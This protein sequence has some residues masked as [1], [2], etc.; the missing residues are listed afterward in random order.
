MDVNLRRWKEVA[1]ELAAIAR[2]KH[3]LIFSGLRGILCQ[4][5]ATKTIVAAGFFIIIIE[6]HKRKLSSRKRPVSLS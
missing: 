5:A 6:A 2:K 4:L 1:A 3:H